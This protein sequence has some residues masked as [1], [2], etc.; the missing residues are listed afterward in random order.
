MNKLVALVFGCAA[1]GVAS[2][3]ILAKAEQSRGPVLITGDRPVTA[4]E[5][6]TKLKMDGW[7]DVVVSRNGRYFQVSGVLN[8]QAGN[9]AVDSLTG[10]L[11]DNDDDDDDD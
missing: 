1:L 8:G 7:S 10:R 3:V 6:T 2:A 5:I 9:I 11:R 4:E